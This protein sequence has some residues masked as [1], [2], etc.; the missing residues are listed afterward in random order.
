MFLFTWSSMIAATLWTLSKTLCDTLK[1]LSG[2]SLVHDP[3]HMV[4][5]WRVITVTGLPLPVLVS[6]LTGFLGNWVES[7]SFLASP[8]L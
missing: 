4:L 6:M 5:N 7:G 1:T 8:R 2:G 3:T